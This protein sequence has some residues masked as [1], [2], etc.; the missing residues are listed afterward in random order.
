MLKNF[1]FSVF[2]LASLFSMKSTFFDNS[3]KE[4]SPKEIV[5]DTDSAKIIKDKIEFDNEEIDINNND[6]NKSEIIL[7]KD[8][9]KGDIQL[10]FKEANSF[11]NEENYKDAL[12]KYNE[13]IKKLKNTTDIQLLKN[14]A[15]ANFLKAYIY[16][17][18]IHD[19][20]EAIKAYNKV[21]DKFKD[22]DNVELLKLYFNAQKNKIS[23]LDRDEAIDVYDDIIDKFKDSTNIEL[24]QKFALAENAKAY[25][26]K[27]EDKIEIY[28]EI[29][30][31]FKN[32]QN[33]KLLKELINAEFS[34]APLLPDDEAID[35]YDEII[36]KFNSLDNGEFEQE[37]ED[38]LFS[39]S[40]LLMSE[41]KEESM[42]MLDEII[43]K[44]KDR[45]DK[46]SSKN[47]EYA[48][49]NNIELALVTNSDNTDY[50]ELANSYLLDKPDTKP[51][52]EMLNILKNAQDINQDEALEEWENTY[53]NYQFENWSFDTLKE[54]NEQMEDSQE[55][56]RIKGYI[57][58][59][60]K[61]NQK[62]Q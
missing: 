8:N 48:V 55:K 34:K 37:V 24:L 5:F 22:S 59:F 41:S 61:H 28:D 58:E 39:K 14:F 43:D 15:G 49:I 30:D 12:N 46:D 33:K 4:N 19:N 36:Q 16:R 52:M 20:D 29:I 32:S 10:L 3:I 6:I 25:R 40:Y 51:Q 2:A 27:G 47:F 13:I 35:V 11:T 31:K 57:N 17:N 26:L 60:I 9:L 18:Y 7:P 53:K 42:E 54:W 62:I 23:L 44:Y 21:V 50:V 56:A 45:D 38:A 1:L